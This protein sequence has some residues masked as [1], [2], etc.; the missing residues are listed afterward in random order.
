[1]TTD[2]V[3]Q[4]CEPLHKLIGPS[5]V[6]LGLAVPLVAPLVLSSQIHSFSLDSSIRLQSILLAAPGYDMPNKNYSVAILRWVLVLSVQR[7][8]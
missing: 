3:E 4:P 2:D 7:A 6:L 1:M 8:M 5:D